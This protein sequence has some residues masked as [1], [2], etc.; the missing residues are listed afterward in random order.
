MCHRQIE[1]DLKNTVI[2]GPANC[3]RAKTT[4][5]K[6]ARLNH[7]CPRALKLAPG[8]C[9]TIYCPY[10]N[11]LSMN[12]AAGSVRHLLNEAAGLAQLL[13]H[14]QANQRV[15]ASLRAGTA[16]LEVLRGL[17]PHT[18]PQLARLRAT[19]RQ[20]VQ[21]LV[22]RLKAEGYVELTRNPAHRRS[23]LVSITEGGRA[24]VRAGMAQETR[25]LERLAV[26]ASEA[27]LTA[28]I[29]LLH[30]LRI[31]AGG[32]ASPEAPIATRSELEHKLTLVKK[33]AKKTRTRKAER[34]AR[35]EPAPA[36]EDVSG[37]L[38]YNL[39]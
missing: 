9:L 12:N 3:N 34:T 32:E 35:F 30:R 4:T 33:P 11:L 14:G 29:A 27:E 36:P 37:E 20:N 25:L 17:G 31:L 22:N 10:D 5:A 1:Y 15:V 19:S 26:G 2:E 16:L 13:R 28:S 18:V 23:D 6:H 38:P 21:V 7:A 39:L 24:T 8:T